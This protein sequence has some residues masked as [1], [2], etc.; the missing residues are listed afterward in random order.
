MKE[1]KYI[2]NNAELM[3][4]W[5]WEK[6]NQIGLI[7]RELVIGSNRKAYWKC[8]NGHEWQAPIANR[9]I[10]NTGCP[11]CSGRKATSGINDLATLYPDIATEW[12]V[13]KNG[14]LLPTMVSP[15]SGKKVWWKC[16]F[17]HEWEAAVE[18]RVRENTGCPYCSGNK[19]LLGFN[20]LET[21]YPD[22][23]AEW[24][25]SQNGNLLPT[26]VTAG[27]CKKVWWNCNNGH[28][29]QA[30]IANRVN[31]NGCPYCSGQKVLS[32]YND[33]HTTN[34]EVASEWHPTKNGGLLPT[35]VTA[36]S[37]RKVW[38]NCT[39]G[40]EWQATVA[41][42]VNGNGC[43]YCSG[44]RALS[45]FN[46]L[47]TLYPDIAK[48]WNTSKN[49]D[50][51]PTMVTAGSSKKV[52]WSCR[53][54]HEWQ[55]VVSRRTRLKTGCP[56]CWLENKTSFP[57]Q[58]I[59][60]YCQQITYA[61]SR[62][63]DFGKEIDIYLPEY[64]I[65]IE[66]NGVFWH[67]NKKDADKD[68]VKFFSKKGIRIITV[69]ESDQN[70]VFGDTIEYIYNSSNKASLNWAIQRL[71][72][73]LESDNISIDASRD[74]SKIYNQYIALEK[75]NSLASKYPEI[76][77]QWN[78]EKNLSLKPEMIMP[79]SNKKIWW[80]CENGHEWQAVVSSRTSGGLG[81]PYCAGQKVLSG[82]NDL[83]TTNPEIAS[84]WHPTKNGDLLPSM[85]SAGAGQKVWWI[86]PVCN[87]DY[88][89]AIYHRS[90]GKGCPYCSSKIIESGVNDLASHNPTLAAEW[91]L[92]RNGDLTPSMV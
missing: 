38:W 45:G 30:T 51:L 20:D 61:E 5:D 67:K 91:N 80:K 27:S 9:A 24:D 37:G 50:L 49:G 22:V 60:Y 33:L 2:I 57:E 53:K 76:A 15:G 87:K 52:W 82:Y 92:E 32:G 41:E 71:F 14:D 10:R 39:D 85:V 13:A 4:E 46:D 72:E 28:K 86:C 43:P 78:F 47:A 84:E 17:G 90:N 16:S 54:G 25:R 42:R 23:A 7:P 66:Y 19:V 74:E 8:S 68:K 44:H 21:L 18:K 69:A 1:K 64:K 31:G 88:Q 62:N 6:N 34:P 73:L 35:M 12:N 59:L 36:G 55:A 75:E 40:H 48:E 65:G 70:A 29:W 58:T 56:V 63:V 3:A 81:C 11:Y 79:N 26:M 89:T 83:C 77:K